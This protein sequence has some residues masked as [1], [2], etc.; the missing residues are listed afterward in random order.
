MPDNGANDR[1]LVVAPLGRDAAIIGA[2]LREVGVASLPCPDLAGLESR[3]GDDVCFCVLTEEALQRLPAQATLPWVAAQP[4]WSDLPFI[5]LAQRQQ[6]GARRVDIAS[7]ISELLGNV[8]FLERP[9]HPTTFVSVARSAGKARQRQYD[10]RAHIVA[11][12]AA[13]E[14]LERLN[15]NLEARVA[16]R[17]AALESAHRKVMEEMLQREHAENLLRQSQKM[18]MIGQLT[19]GIAH[20][21]NNLLMAVLGNLELLR[22][23]VS[24]DA[25]LARL[26]DSAVQGAHRGAA[27]TQRLLA[28]ARRQD[29][30]VQPVDVAR[31]V[32]GMKALIERSTHPRIDLSIGMPAGLPMALADANQLEL[33]LLN[34]VVNARDAMPHGGLLAIGADVAHSAGDEDLAAGTYIR[35]VV[36]DSGTGMDAATLARAREPF[37][38]TKEL[39]KGTGLGLSTVHGLAR[40]L[41]GALRLSSAPGQGTRAEI[42]LPSTDQAERPEPAAAGDATACAALRNLT[43]LVVDD[44]AL[45]GASTAALLEDMGHTSIEA[46]SGE[47]ALGI[48]RSGRPVDLVITDYSM[49]GMTG[50]ELAKAVRAQFPSLPVL[51]A[52]GYAELPPDAEPDLPKLRK[53]YQQNQIVAEIARCVGAAT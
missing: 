33:A 11:S 44:D 22:K 42:W 9:F 19:G 49:P 24:G 38:S 1:A 25:R 28:F 15:S 12:K 16:E 41:R 17:T 32:K 53:P 45:V 7:R 6:G 47:R 30:T 18:E 8:T 46:E 34:L 3:L 5:V 43:I 27:L 51:L 29:L 52:T 23:H 40:Q 2:L 13:Q 20:D 37:F 4:S 36:T 39:G 10:A 14:T 21:F 48:L 31:L 26:V 35:L 50:A